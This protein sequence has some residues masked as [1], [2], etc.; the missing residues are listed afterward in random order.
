MYLLNIQWITVFNNKKKLFKWARD[1]TLNHFLTVPPQRSCPFKMITD[2]TIYIYI[3]YAHIIVCSQFGVALQQLQ[4][5]AHVYRVLYKRHEEREQHGGVAT[6]VVVEGIW[7]EEE[8]GLENKWPVRQSNYET[9][10]F[11]MLM[12]ARWGG[13]GGYKFIAI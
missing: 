12:R 6:A 1:V 11:H 7:C 4:R 2:T 9:L 8:G 10:K 5:C 3:L 13:G